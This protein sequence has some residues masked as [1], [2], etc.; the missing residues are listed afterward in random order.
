MAFPSPPQPILKLNM[1]T[2][3]P[4]KPV[5]YEDLYGERNPDEEFD[6]F[7]DVCEEESSSSYESDKP[8]SIP[9]GSPQKSSRQSPQEGFFA[10]FRTPKRKEPAGESEDGSVKY[11][12]SKR[13]KGK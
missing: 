1:F 7:P 10:R 8:K 6:R 4:G 11:G 5:Y 12:E 2:A 3:P 13:K 9:P